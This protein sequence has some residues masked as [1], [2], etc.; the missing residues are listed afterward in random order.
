MTAAER[1]QGIVGIEHVLGGIIPAFAGKLKQVG[2][3]NMFPGLQKSTL[4]C[5]VHT[6]H[7]DPTPFPSCACLPTTEVGGLCP[8]CLLYLKAFRCSFVFFL[9]TSVHQGCLIQVV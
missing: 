1:G 8:S 3:C 4:S 7:G 5:R 9:W 2:L 6:L